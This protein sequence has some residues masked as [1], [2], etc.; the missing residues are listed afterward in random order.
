MRNILYSSMSLSHTFCLINLGFFFGFYGEAV[1]GNRDINR[2]PHLF[3]YSFVNYLDE[4][5]IEVLDEF[6]F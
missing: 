5:K 6:L 2:L 4:I 1:L 3:V